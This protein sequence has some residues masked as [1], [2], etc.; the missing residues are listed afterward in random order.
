MVERLPDPSGHRVIIL[1]G[2]YAGQEGVC[3]GQAT[4]GSQWMV[5]PDS[6]SEILP[7]EFDRDFGILIAGD[8]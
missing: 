8:N 2:R 4:G 7:M 6:T 1:S 3:L 5:S